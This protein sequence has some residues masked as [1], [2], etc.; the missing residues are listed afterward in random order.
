MKAKSSYKPL[1]AALYKAQKA[2]L[3]AK[4][5]VCN[6][7][8]FNDYEGGGRYRRANY[9]RSREAR[10]KRYAEK[11]KWLAAAVILAV[12]SGVACGWKEGVLYFDLPAGQVSFHSDSKFGAPDYAGTWDECEGTTLAR[13]KLA[14]ERLKMDGEP[15]DKFAAYLH[16]RREQ[17]AA[18]LRECFYLVTLKKPQ[19]DGKAQFLTPKGAQPVFVYGGYFTFAESAHHEYHAR[20][21]T[22]YTS[23]EAALGDIEERRARAWAEHT[24]TCYVLQCREKRGE[25]H[26]KRVAT[27]EHSATSLI[28]A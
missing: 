4:A 15:F 16:S 14:Q 23:K 7:V 2:N 18:L 3:A 6:G 19:W 27:V 11:S 10:E 1:L 8:H 17:E 22:R 12:E 21:A 5:T 13:I 24:V 20:D 25:I 28:P 26:Y 9:G